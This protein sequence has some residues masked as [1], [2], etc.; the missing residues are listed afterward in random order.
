ML[1]RMQAIQDHLSIVCA[2]S[3]GTTKEIQLISA[4][5]RKRRSEPLPSDVGASLGGHSTRSQSP[6]SSAK[7]EY[8]LEDEDEIEE[9]TEEDTSDEDEGRVVGRKRR[10]NVDK[11]GTFYLP[12]DRSIHYCDFGKDLACNWGPNMVC[13]SILC[14]K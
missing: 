1:D 5:H 11:E 8:V 3:P 7:S 9:L 14:D 4:G 2:N 6:S 12:L 13:T 10:E